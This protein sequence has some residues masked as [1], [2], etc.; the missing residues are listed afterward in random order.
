VLD[1]VLLAERERQRAQLT[2][3]ERA[4]GDRRWAFGHVIVDEAQELTAM[5]WRMIMRRCPSRSMTLV[6]D[7]AQ[8]GAEGGAAS[9]REALEPHVGDRWRLAELTV[10]Y[11]T[12][13]EI[14]AEAAAVLAKIDPGCSPP[15]SVRRIGVHPWRASVPA[16]D[17]PERMRQLVAGELASVDGGTVAVLCPDSQVAR[18]RAAVEAARVSVHPVRRAK[19]LEFD[20]VIVLDP[21]G[22]AAGA[23][24]HSDLYVAM[25]RST[26]RL[27]LVSVD[28]PAG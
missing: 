4:A 18:V 27:G 7:V 16:P 28:R 23:R 24:G 9:W 26:R 2:A 20:S 11:R 10:N 5:D 6:G 13:A 15:R 17:A 19:G 12:P 8:T 14:M 21:D 3:A 22:I 25:T 1:A